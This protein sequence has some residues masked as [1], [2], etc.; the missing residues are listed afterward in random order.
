M[1]ELGQTLGNDVTARFVRLLTNDRQ[2]QALAREAMESASYETANRYSV[3]SGELMGQA[4]ADETQTLAYMSYDVARETLTPLMTANH[5]AV[6][7]VTNSI[8]T[9]MNKAAGV[10]LAPAPM[11]LDTSR[12]N[13]LAVVVSQCDTMAQAREVIAEPLINSSQSIVDRGIRDNAKANSKAGLKAIIIRRTETAGTRVRDQFVRRGNKVYGAYKRKYNVPCKWCSDLAGEYEYESVKDTGNMVFRRHESCRCIILYK[14]GS[15]IKNVRTQKE[16]T[17]R[18]AEEQRLYIELMEASKQPAAIPDNDIT[19]KI[20]EPYYRQMREKIDNAPESIQNVW[21]KNENDIRIADL[22]SKKQFAQRGE[23]HVD[24]DTAPDP[25]AAGINWEH[26]WQVFIHESSHGIDAINAPANDWFFS[27]AYKNGLFPK[28]IKSEVQALVK[29]R[30]VL[31]KELI[32]Q[33]DFQRLADI[34]AISR[35]EVS[36][37]TNNP[38]ALTYKKELAYKSIQHDIRSI[39]IE[40]RRGI[41]DIMDG[42]TNSR[43]IGGI[44]HSKAYWQS[45]TVDG[46]ARGLSTE[47]F[48]EMIDSATCDP[49]G[50]EIIKQYLPKSV[51]VFDEMMEELGG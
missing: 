44:G 31:I 21:N 32:D 10:G 46:V 30:G 1:T 41:S 2:A 24:I 6:T 38:W 18:S 14:N 20:G 43:I 45:T 13:G 34:G 11:E 26:P 33:K 9:N 51:A 36:W 35:Y 50:F 40:H 28:T 19:K 3:R 49:E 22:H 42:A 7:A 29:E 17:P 25:L 37:Y 48:A 4:L 8:Q 39:P 5:E 16:W 27:S 23:I 12:I 15:E 47:A